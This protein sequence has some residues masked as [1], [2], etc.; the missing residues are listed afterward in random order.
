[1]TVSVL[2]KEAK[3]LSKK[4]RLRLADEIWATVDDEWTDST[5]PESL[6]A[7]LSRRYEA[8]QKNPNQG[9]PWPDAKKRILEKL[10]R[11]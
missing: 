9:S 1:M 11:K 3:K 7:E 8:F 4:D 10:K 6:K 2:L 5:M